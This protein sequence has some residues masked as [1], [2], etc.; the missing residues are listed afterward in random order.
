MICGHYIQY[1]KQAAL[2][3]IRSNPLKCPY[4]SKGLHVFVLWINKMIPQGP[5]YFADRR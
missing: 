3:S 2:G 4:V 1:W 5:I